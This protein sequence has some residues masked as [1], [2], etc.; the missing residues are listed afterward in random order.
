MFG[1]P[2]TMDRV[3]VLT[4]HR[5]AVAPH[6]IFGKLENRDDSVESEQHGVRARTQPIGT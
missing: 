5:G 1:S 6:G 3:L 2:L 4:D